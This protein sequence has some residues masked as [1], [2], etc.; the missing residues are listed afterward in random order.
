MFYHLHLP[1]RRNGWCQE[2]KMVDEMSIAFAFPPN[3][4]TGPNA[5]GGKFP[6]VAFELK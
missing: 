1:I 5:V 4:L 2:E 3:G 6:P